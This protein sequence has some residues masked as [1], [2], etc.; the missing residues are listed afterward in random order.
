MAKNL[1]ALRTLGIDHILNAAY[2]DPQVQ[3]GPVLQFAPRIGFRS[4]LMF[5]SQGFS[6]TVFSMQDSDDQEIVFHIHRAIECIENAA[7]L[8]AKILVHWC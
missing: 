8:Q 3:H 5:V 2:L 6:V 4:K 1:R 7:K